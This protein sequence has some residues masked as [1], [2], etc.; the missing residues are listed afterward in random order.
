MSVSEVLSDDRIGDGISTDEERNTK[1][2]RFKVVGGDSTD[3][4]MVD[5][6]SVRGV[7]WKEK[8]LVRNGSESCDGTSDV[9]LVIE[10]G[11]ILQSSINGIPAIDFSERLRNI[12]VRDMETTVVVKL[13][14]RNIGYGVLLN[15]ISSLW[16][17]SQPFRLMDVENGYYL[18]RFQSRDDYD[19]ALT[20][21]PWIVFGHYLTVQPWT[22]DFDPLRPFPSVVMAWISFP[23]LP[24]FLYRKRILEEIG[25]LVGQ[26]VKLDIKTDSGARGQFARMAVSIDLEKPLT[27][28]VSINGRMQR[29][30]FEALPTVCFSCGNYGHLKSSCFSSLTD[31]NIHGGKEDSPKAMD[32]E[33]NPAAAAAVA[34]GPW[35]VVQRKSRRNQ[36]GKR[37]QKAKVAEGNLAGSRFAALNSLDKQPVDLGTEN[38]GLK[39][40]NFKQGEFIKKL[41][42]N[43]PGSSS[44][45]LVE[46]NKGKEVLG[47][48]SFIGPAEQ[49]TGSLEHTVQLGPA[50]DLQNKHSSL[51]FNPTFEGPLELVVDLNPNFLDPKR[52]SAVNFKEN[53]D[54]KLKSTGSNNR[55]GASNI[56]NVLPKGYGLDNKKRSGH[57][58]RTLNK[59]IHGRGG[60]FKIAGSSRVPHL[61]AMNSMAKLI[62][63][64]VETFTDKGCASLKFL[65]VFREYNREHKPD[66]ISLIETRVNG[67]KADS[68]IA[69]LGFHCS[70]RVEATRFSGGIWI[71]WKESVCVKVLKNHS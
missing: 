7:S 41:K 56:L 5:T 64:Q 63:E 33:A 71:C 42:E 54:H 43:R 58:G 69:K 28:Q 34:F 1:K 16:K 44:G 29:V 20:Q 27:S 65:R 8:L 67:G 30:E 66:L 52:H 39:E 45:L 14:G 19:L 12:L 13:L 55:L 36:A 50:S 61:D 24:G 22:I 31:R 49:T 59:T 68:I 70:H 26:V 38:S 62:G 10:D 53:S 60:R 3:N 51:H 18:V 40:I 17:P 4:M 47:Q 37:N 11:D 46:G 35:M 9:D 2:V 57:N 32:K 15:R 25:N 21:G 48:G 6:I 23:G